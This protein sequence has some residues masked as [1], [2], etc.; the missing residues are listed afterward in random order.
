MA[1]L[2]AFRRR[3]LLPRLAATFCA[4]V[5]PSQFNLRLLHS[6]CYQRCL[7]IVAG[8]HFGPDY[9]YAATDTNL[10][11]ILLG[12][13]LALLLWELPTK[14]PAFA[15]HPVMALVSLIAIGIL[16]QLPERMQ[17]I[18][19]TPAVAPF[20]AILVLQGIAYDYRILDTRV[21]RYLGRI[22]YGVYVWGFVAIAF[23]HRIRHEVKHTLV[24]GVV[25]AIASASY[26]AVERPIQ[27]FGRRWLISRNRHSLGS[28][29]HPIP[30]ESMA[31]EEGL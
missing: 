7:E 6:R 24:F 28:R 23:T 16:A 31:G 20:A 3:A 19:A 17:D 14:L 13:G 11:A 2:V 25:I 4:C 5:E 26:Y 30:H 8:V 29:F 1:Y 21:M 22:S 10:V 27:S 18:W 9:A 15:L 12:C